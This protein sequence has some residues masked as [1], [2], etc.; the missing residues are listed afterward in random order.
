MAAAAE[1]A[2]DVAAA[3]MTAAA[4]TATAMTAAMGGLRPRAERQRHG[5]RQEDFEAFPHRCHGRLHIP[6]R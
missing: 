5:D 4:M 3:A 6:Y 1:P 2:T